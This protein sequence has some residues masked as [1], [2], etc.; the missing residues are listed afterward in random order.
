MSVGSITVIGNWAEL[1][2]HP[3]ER[4]KALSASVW[5][6]ADGAIVDGV[7]NVVY[8]GTEAILSDEV[9]NAV[10]TLVWQDK[11]QYRLSFGEYTG[12]LYCGGTGGYTEGATVPFAAIKDVPG[13]DQES[14]VLTLN[15]IRAEVD[16]K[17]SAQVPEAVGPVLEEQLADETSAAYA[18][19]TTTVDAAV[20]DAVAGRVE[21]LLD[22]AASN[23]TT[24]LNAL[25]VDAKTRGIR[26]VRIPAGMTVDLTAPLIAQSGV[27]LVSD[28][29]I[30]RAS[31]ALVRL[32]DFNNTTAAA[33]R[34]VTFDLAGSLSGTTVTNGVTSNAIRAGAGAVDTLIEGCTLINSGTQLTAPEMVDFMAGAVRPVVRGCTFKTVYRGVRVQGAVTDA[35]IDGN[36]FS[37][38]GS[39]CIYLINSA[40]AGSADG[41]LIRGNVV[42]SVSQTF[43]DPRQPI[44][45]QGV[46]GYW[47]TGVQVVD[48]RIAGE[49]GKAHHEGSDGGSLLGGIAD[50]IS[51]HHV[52]GF[53]VRGNVIRDGGEAGITVAKQSK[54]G[55]VSGNTITGC[56][57][58]PFAIDGT[59]SYVREVEITGN[60]AKNSGRELSP[61]TTGDRAG[62]HCAVYAINA[63]GLHVHGNTFTDDQGTATQRAALYNGDGNDVLVGVNLLYGGCN[64]WTDDTSTQGG[65]TFVVQPRRRTKSAA[66]SRTNATVAADP[67]LQITYGRYAVVEIEALIK[68]SA[69]PTTGRL[70]LGLTL[71]AGATADWHIIGPTGGATTAAASSS[72]DAL[73][74]ASVATVG[75]TTSGT[76][77]E[78]FRVAGV[79][80]LGAT[81]GQVGLRW[82]QKEAS[83]TA[84]VLEAGS[85]MTWRRIG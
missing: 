50:A 15:K 30:V 32:M 68:Y 39:R 24:S 9:G 80:T 85:R 49:P 64:G 35:V 23:P 61:P 55:V 41:V 16:A 28:G 6:P 70:A 73:T 8:A 62:V 29:A 34:G 79:V 83:A 13:G 5:I 77:V 71:P 44:A 57:T 36:S 84:T 51:V 66:T 31:G 12:T 19:V 33:V 38:W 48:N 42:R 78:T 26:R 45:I 56:N 46:D 63:L 72:W 21:L 11:A 10:L 75:G 58:S 4:A 27:A 60:V 43:G 59:G 22:P 18:A 37:D 81:G 20:G 1:A 69:A 47:H 53:V 76:V 7:D 82:A 52:D 2:G 67:D 74:A 54:N 40:A 14:D 3:P 65:A 17:I 25:L